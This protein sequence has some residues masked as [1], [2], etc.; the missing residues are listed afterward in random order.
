MADMAAATLLPCCRAPSAHPGGHPSSRRYRTATVGYVLDLGVVAVPPGG[1][2]FERPRRWSCPRPR[3]V[4]G[5]GR[6]SVLAAG[7]R[8]S[9][10]EA[11]HHE[12]ARAAQR[13][14]P[15]GGARPPPPGAGRPPA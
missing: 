14:E 15:A 8:E 5:V 10:A 13:L 12:P 6:M 2:G 1:R 9:Q 4:G 7:R 11:D 3:T